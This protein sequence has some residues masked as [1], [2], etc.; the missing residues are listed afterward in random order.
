DPA[1]TPAEVKDAFMSTAVDWGQ[2]GYD[3][4]TGAGRL[5]VYAALR[6]AG[7]P[8]ATPPAVPSHVVWQDSGDA[9]QDFDVADAGAPLALTLTGAKSQVFE[10]TDPDGNVLTAVADTPYRDWPSRQKELVIK[11]PAPGRYTAQVSGAGDFT[12]DVSG[13]L[14]PV[15]TTKPAL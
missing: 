8:L 5:D 7:A 12:V 15:D 10:L 1:L 3:T 9:Q 11:A 2:P 13:H 14:M 6:R 4:D